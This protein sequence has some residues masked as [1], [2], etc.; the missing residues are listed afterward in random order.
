[1]ILNTTNIVIEN[2]E[3]LDF[4]R[5]NEKYNL[6]KYEIPTA[7]NCK[8]T[9]NSDNAFAR[10]HNCYREQLDKPYYFWSFKLGLYVLFPTNE[11]PKPL[12]FGF[13]DSTVEPENIAFDDVPL[14]VLMKLLVADYFY[15]E[16]EKKQRFCQSKFFMLGNGRGSIF[17]TVR[18]ELRHDYTNPSENGNKEFYI[19]P[20]A[21]TILKKDKKYEKEEYLH[22]KIF[23]QRIQ[24]DD[25]IYFRQAKIDAVKKWKL[26]GEEVDFFTEPTQLD[27]KNLNLKRANLA[28]HREKT[29]NESR[30]FVTYKFQ[31]NFCEYL[32]KE[33]DILVKPKQTEFQSI[34]DLSFSTRKGFSETGLALREL[35]TIFV[36]DNRL[37]NNET[38]KIFNNNKL[39][40]FIELL[41]AE[42]FKEYG[43]QFVAISQDQI[44]A[45]KAILIVQDYNK[46]D[47]EVNEDD[48]AIGYLAKKGYKED[49][50]V[51]LYS[52]YKNIPKQTISLNPNKYPKKN[53]DWTK[54]F[55][56]NIELTDD[57]KTK[58]SVCLNEL[59]LKRL[60]VRNIQPDKDFVFYFMS[61]VKDYFFLYDYTLMY[62]EDNTFQFLNF[63]Q[64][65]KHLHEKLNEFGIQYREIVQRF[66]EKYKYD[67]KTDEELYEKLSN[68]HFIISKDLI[69]EIEETEE[70]LLLNYKEIEKQGFANRTKK[71]VQGTQGVSLSKD[72][73]SYIVGDVNPIKQNMPRANKIRRL[74]FYKGNPEE[75]RKKILKT[76]T[77]RFVRNKQYTVYPFPFDLIKLYNEDRKY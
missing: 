41:N 39:A 8:K 50:K 34:D 27:R 42:Y 59:Y 6:I 72:N 26:N 5:L 19:I 12:S 68:T 63:A 14:H 16:I 21:T 3:N 64:N 45:D 29:Y 70:R 38:N 51:K 32:K 1:M 43:I 56:Y 2:A 36:L 65:K 9:N 28:W 33:F 46:D 37:V 17:T 53:E 54:Y 35:K 66:K 62:V 30:G 18:L 7:F 55:D 44:S 49:P 69:V 13:L 57:I 47:F 10:F 22:T 74:D 75:H 77:V 11:T 73:N 60:V 4:T 20:Q 61:K 24:K 76:L 40:V 15:N 31:T 67:E 52:T 25:T 58:L 71:I 23:Y 48:K